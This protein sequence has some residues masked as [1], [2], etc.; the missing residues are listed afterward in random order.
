MN[1]IDAHITYAA[2]CRSPANDARFHLVPGWVL[3]S[4]LD[5]RPVDTLVPLGLGIH[6]HRNQFF[7]DFPGASL[8][9]FRE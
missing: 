8:P 9:S 6:P 3:L 4:R 2:L 7:I 5:C 1:I